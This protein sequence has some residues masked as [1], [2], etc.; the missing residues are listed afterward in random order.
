MRNGCASC[1]RESVDEAGVLQVGIKHRQLL[2]QE[3]PLVDDRPARQ[4]ADVKTVD[5]LGQH[6]LL[7]AP[8]DQEQ[9]AFELIVAHAFGVA[10]D[11]LLDLGPRGDRLLAND[12]G[13]DRDLAPAQDGVVEAENLGLHDRAAALLPGEVGA[14]QE[15]HADRETPRHVLVAVQLLPEEVLRDL[16]IDPGAVS[17]LAVGVDRAAMP[18]CAQGIDRR[19]DHLAPWLTVDRGDEADAAGGVLV[20]RIVQPVTCQ[21]SGVSPVVRD[22]PLRCRCLLGRHRTAPQDAKASAGALA[23]MCA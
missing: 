6:L 15:H 20:G 9:L 2:G 7:D 22:K 11:D 1:H 10:D 12:R 14:R 13:V 8:A 19:L 23:R 16:D 21:M 5:V 4:G 17:G 18:H 3:Q